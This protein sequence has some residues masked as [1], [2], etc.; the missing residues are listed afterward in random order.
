A[1]SSRER[2]CRSRKYVMSGG[3]IHGKDHSRAEVSRIK[4][5]QFLFW[6]AGVVTARSQSQ[7]GAPLLCD[8]PL[9]RKGQRFPPPPPPP[10]PPPPADPPPGRPPPP[11]EEPPPPMPP[12]PPPGPRPPPPDPPPPADPPPPFAPKFSVPA[13]LLPS[14]VVC[15][16]R[17]KS[18]ACAILEHAS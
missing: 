18:N 4:W 2:E 6:E 10:A 11:P 5:L 3:T 14:R 16:G 13:I 7:K 15:Y 8:A 12:P 17:D 1:S 9:K